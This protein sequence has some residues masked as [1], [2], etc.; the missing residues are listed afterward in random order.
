V[1]VVAMMTVVVA[2]AVVVAIRTVR[3]RCRNES[4]LVD[5][6]GGQQ[7]LHA[8]GGGNQIGTKW[9]LTTQ[10]TRAPAGQRTI[11]KH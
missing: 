10:H 8:I 9:R 5:S 7:C 4:A 11:K 6:A 2:V 3:T 1:E